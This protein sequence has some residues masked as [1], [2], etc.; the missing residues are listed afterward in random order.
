MA[1]D[2]YLILDGI[3]GESVAKGHT[4][5]IEVQTA[6]WQV[7]NKA[8]AAGTGQGAGKPSLQDFHFTK[9]V[10]KASATLFQHCCSGEHIAT[11]SVALSQTAAG[12]SFLKID[13]KDVI[14]TSYELGLSA[15]D[16]AETITLS[17]GTIVMTYS[18]QDAT[19]A[20]KPTGTAG[21]DLGKNAKV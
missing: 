18:T 1:I 3:P 11:A 21:W 7:S 20:L 6:S 19:G 14:I 12:D 15:N 9:K 2:I 13:M 8:P 5:E 10:D 4:G 17:Y 16:P